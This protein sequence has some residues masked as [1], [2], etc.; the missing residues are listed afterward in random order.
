MCL[1]GSR[2]QYLPSYKMA[3][4]KSLHGVIKCHDLIIVG[5]LSKVVHYIFVVR[6][7]QCV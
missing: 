4:K 5:S 6:L 3:S 1:W 2:Y 7:G